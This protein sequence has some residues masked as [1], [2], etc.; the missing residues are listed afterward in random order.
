MPGLNFFLGLCVVLTDVLG[1][2]F[3][4]IWRQRRKK[5]PLFHIS[6]SFSYDVICLLISPGWYVLKIHFFME[7]G[8]KNIKFNNQFTSCLRPNKW[9]SSHRLGYGKWTG[10]MSTLA[11]FQFNHVIFNPLAKESRTDEGARKN[12]QKE[13]KK[14][15]QASLSLN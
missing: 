7:L 1:H 11:K 15:V 3:G 2:T 6:F 9:K 8:Q 5:N 14:Y 10:M 13:L 4:W 12:L